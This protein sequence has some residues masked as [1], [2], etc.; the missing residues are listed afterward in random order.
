MIKWILLFIPIISSAQT[1]DTFTNAKAYASALD[2]QLLKGI[3]NEGHPYAY[4]SKLNVSVAGVYSDAQIV[5]FD[6]TNKQVTVKTLTGNVQG[7]GWTGFMDFSGRIY[8]VRGTGTRE[9][10]ELNLKYPDSIGYRSL[11]NSSVNDQGFAYSF[12]FGADSSIGIGN[13][14]S[15][16]STDFAIK[17]WGRDT[18]VKFNEPD[19]FNGYNY[20]VRSDTNDWVY[21]QTG[22]NVYRIIAVNKITQAKKILLERNDVFMDLSAYTGGIFAYRNDQNKLYHLT[23]G[24][25]VLV[26]NDYNK[27]TQISYRETRSN[28]ESFSSTYPY[29]GSFYDAAKK[30]L[31]YATNP[32]GIYN[33]ANT[34]FDSIN[35]DGGSVPKGVGAMMPDRYDTNVIV[36]VGNPYG[37]VHKYYIAQDSVATYGYPGLNVYSIYQL[38]DSIWFLSGYPSGVCVKW[39]THKYFNAESWVNGAYAPV[40]STTNPKLIGYFASVSGFD[41]AND[42]TL[43]DGRYL[44]ATG[45]NIRD[46]NTSS[47]GVID[48]TKDSMYGYNEDKMVNKS[49]VDITVWGKKL[50]YS[51]SDV[52]GGISYLYIYNPA[53]NSMLDSV[54]LG[55][56]S[57]G[58][59]FIIG[60]M[61]MGIA[62]DTSNDTH[63]ID[64]TIFYKYNL[65][66]KQLS[67]YKKVRGTVNE[68]IWMPDGYI[69]VNFTI[70]ATPASSPVISPIPPDF[71]L[72]RS[73]ENRN[74][75]YGSNGNYFCVDLG[76]VRHNGIST[77]TADPETAE[78]K[79]KILIEMLK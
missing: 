32:A 69:G 1:I 38:N 59:T 36:F 43:V 50:I 74:Y 15:P 9:V 8:T 33:P 31:Y 47:V 37:Y 39:D 20:S 40:S 34:V 79:E 72:H 71:Y 76:I 60:Y 17:Y 24:D 53:T 22:E 66:T 25:T 65:S 49:W 13:C 5:K 29:V 18:L 2:L 45:N 48:V 78:G 57:Y 77:Y 23:G 3:T 44:C 14:C 35:Y 54:N 55:F 52:N 30:R 68:A 26:A 28:N 67:Y 41:H 6:L 19:E 63:T 7:V 61:L 56:K 62:Q 51:T 75:R 16:T 70:T 11:E 46:E 27:G 12:Q 64:S 42:L 73:I 58:K 21:V 10:I 4:A